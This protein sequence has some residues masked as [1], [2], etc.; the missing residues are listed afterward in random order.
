MKVRECMALVIKSLA[1]EREPRNLLADYAGNHPAK[2][3]Q[4]MN[5]FSNFALQADAIALHMAAQKPDIYH[6]L[7]ETL[8]EKSLLKLLEKAEVVLQ[9]L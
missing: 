2:V 8:A 7:G 5:L 3:G 4:A 9:I 6:E 1:K